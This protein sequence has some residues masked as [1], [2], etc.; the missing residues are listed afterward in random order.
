MIFDFFRSPDAG[1]PNSQLRAMIASNVPQ[2]LYKVVG[3]EII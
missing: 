1:T 3:Y 2:E